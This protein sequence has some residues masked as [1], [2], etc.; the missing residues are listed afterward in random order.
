M[1]SQEYLDLGLPEGMEMRNENGGLEIR[2]K[3]FSLI[4]I[5][6]AFFAIIW[7]GFL[8]MWY[9]ILSSIS[10]EDGSGQSF[11][12]IFYL[13]PLIHVAV[14]IGLLYYSLCGFLNK[15]LIRADWENLTIKHYPLPWPGNKIISRQ[16]I[17]QLYVKQ[18]VSQGRGT[19]TTYEV[20]L[21]TQSGRDIKLLSNLP[22]NEQAA[23]IEQE[24]EKY[25]QIHNIPVRGEYS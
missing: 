18:K 22:N 4:N 25:L 24:V 2:R 7:Y 12:L 15:T 20:H 8:V 16:D 14:G 17:K 3:W 1:T 6:T 19:T 5:F 23:F 11:L 9:S 13:F 10:F 21:L